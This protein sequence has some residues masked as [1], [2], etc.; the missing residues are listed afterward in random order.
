MSVG[1]ALLI[2]TVLEMVL[3]ELVPKSLAIAAPERAALLLAP[4]LRIYG[5]V[6]GPLIRMLNGAANVVVRKLGIEPKEELEAVRTLSELAVLIKTSATE[7]TIANSASRLLTRSIRFTEKCAA[8]VLIPRVRLHAIAADATVEQLVTLA[9]QTGHSR[10]PVFR[11]DIDDVIGV[12]HVKS[13]HTLAPAV[14]RTTSVRSIM[15]EA[16]IVPE[17]RALQPLLH[18]MQ[19]SRNHLVVVVDEHG[20]TAGIVTLE[21]LLEEIVGEIDDEYDALTPAFDVD[22][23]RLDS[24]VPASLHADEVEDATGFSMPDGDYETLAGF[25]LDQLG[26]VP[27]VGEQ[28]EFKEWVLVVTAMDRRRIVEVD[29]RRRAADSINDPTTGAAAAPPEAT[30]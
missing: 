1:I 19:A 24:S 4:F 5:I 26:H 12:V 16:D 30:A 10:F 23:L 2:A 22:S 20:G 29:V 18:D 3:G 6:F 15:V 9:A 21:D 11:A 13:V 28:V 7:G 25:L 27:V 8:D 17:T 14:R